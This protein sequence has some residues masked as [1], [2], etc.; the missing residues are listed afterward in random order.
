MTPAPRPPHPPPP[1]PGDVA[2]GHAL[3]WLGEGWRLFMKAPGPW[4]VQALI[5]FV[6]IAALGMLP[7]L[8]W[9][10]APVALLM[11]DGGYAFAVDDAA[12]LWAAEDAALR[13]APAGSATRPML[14]GVLQ[15][16]TQVAGLVDLPALHAAA[17]ASLR[18]ELPT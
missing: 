12:D 14:R 18:A 3:N 16:G 4:V 15:R 6:I 11:A 17:V 10:A 5:F 7:V 2:P 8:G 1:A 9:A 13:P